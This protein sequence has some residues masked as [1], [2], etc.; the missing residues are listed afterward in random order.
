MIDVGNAFGGKTFDIGKRLLLQI[1]AAASDA[2]RLRVEKKQIEVVRGIVARYS[3][4]NLLFTSFDDKK[5]KKTCPQGQAFFVLLYCTKKLDTYWE[6]RYISPA[7]SL[8]FN[9]HY[10]TF[11]VKSPFSTSTTRVSFAC[12]SLAI[13]VFAMSVSTLLCKYRLSGLA[14]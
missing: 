10:F 14:P 12:K 1:L 5:Q 6:K 4:S 9:L 7:F 2:H 11:T 3:G 13:I 8:K